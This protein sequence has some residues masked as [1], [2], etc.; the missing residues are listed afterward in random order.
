MIWLLP[1]TEFVPDA[2]SWD[3]L[4]KQFEAEQRSLDWYNRYENFKDWLRS[5]KGAQIS[6]RRIR[7]I[8]SRNICEIDLM[9]LDVALHN[10]AHE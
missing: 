8:A 10:A 2:T 1:V 3:A 7:Q 6:A 4:M 5:R 9:A